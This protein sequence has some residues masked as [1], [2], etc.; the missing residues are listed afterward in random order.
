MP[1]I[2]VV[3]LGEEFEVPSDCEQDKYLEW[4]GVVLVE[5]GDKRYEVGAVIGVPESERGTCRA[6][7]S[8]VS[9]YLSAWYAD[10]SDWSAVG[11]PQ[12]LAPRVIAE[13]WRRRSSLWMQARGS[14]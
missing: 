11:V 13:I 14:N 1:A 3:G 9:T 12:E 7:Q 5:I 2:K 10:S 4:Y 8:G 6:A